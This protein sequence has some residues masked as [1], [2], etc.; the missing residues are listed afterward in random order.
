MNL[1]QWPEEEDLVARAFD[2]DDDDVQL[3][4]AP[5]KRPV[6][7]VLPGDLVV[8]RDPGMQQRTSVVVQAPQ[9]GMA[10]IDPILPFAAGALLAR[11]RRRTT[12][13]GRGDGLVR[14]GRTVVR[15]RESIDESVGRPTLRQGSRGPA[16]ADAQ[17]RLNGAHTR[18]TGRGEPGLER[19]PLVVDSVFGPNTRA[20]ATSFQRLAFPGQPREWDGVIGPKTW[21]ALLADGESQVIVPPRIAIDPGRWEAIL[22]PHTGGRVNLRT[23]NAVRALVDGPET[24]QAMADDMAAT[25]GPGDYIYLL[26]W[27][28]FDNFPL[29][30]GGDF[31]TI[32]TAAAA[33][34]VEVAAMYWD[35][36]G[37]QNTG[38]VQR[39]NATRG[40]RAILDDLTTNNTTASTVR[41]AAAAA[42]ARLN[43]L[44]I[45]VIL[46]IIEPDIARLA[47]SH[48]QKLLIVK[49]GETLV[50]YCGGIDMNPDRV[51][52]VA[53]NRGQPHH[54]THC[55]VIGPSAH[56][57]LST[58]I[59]RWRHH[60]SSAGLG[61]LR[62]EGE[63]VPAPVARPAPGDAPFGGPAAVL[64]ART[65]NPVHPRPPLVVAE[66][67]IKP[68]LLEAI[69]NA[70][71]F[72]YCEDQYL[73]DLDTADALAAAIPRLAHVTILIPG[74]AIT[75]TLSKEY[76]RDFV[77]RVH[78]RLSP[79]DRAKFGVFQLTVPGV[80]PPPFG[81]H[82]YVHSKS[83][84]FDDEL[85]VIGTANCNRR[86]YTFDSEVSAFIFD[87]PSDN[88]RS[89]AQQYR[90]KL[91]EHH[92]GV[93]GSS[94]ADGVAGARL[95]RS[96][97]RPPSARV[98]S[99]D[100]RLPTGFSRAAL[101]QRVMN[102]AA[103][104]L[105]DIF[106]PVP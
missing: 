32:Y 52:V 60:P 95:W 98:A 16:V 5:G 11:P 59:S 4:A 79:A 39:M 58:F 61:S 77:E 14:S 17:Q 83:W 76:R 19:C 105:R 26:G 2:P 103:D 62:G 9:A 6:E 57:L 46:E 97:A 104:R 25:R 94:L 20:A 34:G 71:R 101:E 27:D 66:R 75:V 93:P 102:I 55:R 15:M 86:S 49:R 31:R 85:A 89:W 50:G 69:R 12:Q 51:R 41:L 56:D 37:F 73:F 72:I 8:A 88:R 40:C 47:G 84:V 21:T 13:L 82:T 65:F 68:I 30:S 24:F 33:R 81:D 1:R 18:R 22:R 91:W 67:S 48:H 87:R 64:I 35:Q 63:P 53:P 28:N 29:A 96:A 54:D 100:H 90:M 45:P 7:P 74:N 92:L 99:F 23:G 36:I 10:M 106:D 78:A 43:P 42:V 70:R 3:I 38:A 80:T 44:L